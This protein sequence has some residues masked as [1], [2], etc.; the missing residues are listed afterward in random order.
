MEFKINYAL[1]EPIRNMSKA[2]EELNKTYKDMELGDNSGLTALE[3]YM[4]EEKDI[5]TLIENYKELVAIDTADMRDMV[6]IMQGV[7]RMISAALSSGKNNTTPNVSPDENF[8]KF[9]KNSTTSNVS[10]E[11]MFS[12]K[13]NLPPEGNTP[14]ITN[15]LQR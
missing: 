2:G 3:K 15:P 11:D 1:S 5:K 9:L 13:T 12:P 14:N 7:D 8:Q 4:Q 10:L 6:D